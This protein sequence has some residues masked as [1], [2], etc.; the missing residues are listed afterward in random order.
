MKGKSTFISY[1]QEDD[2]IANS[3]TSLLRTQGNTIFLDKDSIQ[4][5]TKW[6][7]ALYDAIKKSDLLIILWCCH[8]A[9]SEWVDYEFELGVQFQKPIIPVI[10]CKFPTNKEISEFQ[11][12]NLSDVITHPC[13]NNC[14]KTNKIDN[15]LAPPPIPQASSSKAHSSKKPNPIKIILFALSILIVGIV[16]FFIFQKNSA[17]NIF[18]MVAAI[19]VILFTLLLITRKLKA[20]KAKYEIRPIKRKVV[21]KREMEGIFK[22]ALSNID[23]NPYKYYP[24]KFKSKT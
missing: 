3:V 18:I 9:K 6:K 10:C 4:P 5:G 2:K 23:K 1:S 16:T 17:K 19:A 7:E 11:W 20:P 13:N 24:N 8:S 12:I 15:L 22:E 14:C 21:P